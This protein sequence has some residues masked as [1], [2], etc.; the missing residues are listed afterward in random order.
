MS[1]SQ[2]VFLAAHPP[3]RA[4]TERYEQPM[5]LPQL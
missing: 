4:G 5:L 1:Q 3:K 2:R